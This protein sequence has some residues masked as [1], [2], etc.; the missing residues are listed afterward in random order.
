[1]AQYVIPVIEY[2]EY[3]LPESCPLKLE[4]SY[5][6][7]EVGYEGW[8]IS[9]QNLYKERLDNGQYRCGKCGKKFVHEYYLLLHFERKHPEFHNPVPFSSIF[10]ILQSQVCLDKYMNVFDSVS[11]K[12]PPDCRTVDYQRSFIQCQ[13]GSI[14]LIDHTESNDALLSR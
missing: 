6:Y 10:L 5:Y 2:Y 12:K 7:L 8:I 13:V 3:T 14:E 1:M 9:G 4:N 11:G